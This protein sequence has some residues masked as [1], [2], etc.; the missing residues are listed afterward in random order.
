MG[1]KNLKAIAIRGTTPIPIA[2][3]S[4]FQSLVKAAEIKLAHSKG[5]KGMRKGGSI[6]FINPNFN[7]LAFK[8]YQDDTWAPERVNLITPDV[9][10]EKYQVGRSGCYNCN[11]KCGRLYKVKEGEFAGLE[12]EGV[13]INAL[14]G[15]GSNLD[16]ADPSH[17]I[18]ANAVCNQYGLNI[19]SIASIAGWV[20]DCFERGIITK[21][22]LGYRVDWGD[23]HSFLRLAKDVTFRNGLGD[24]LA[25]GIQRASKIIGKDSQRLA[26]IS[27]G[28]EINEGRLRSHRAWALG[29]MTSARGGGH[30]N[31]APATEG[32][33]FDEKLCEEIYG[34][35]NVNKPMAYENKAE[36]VV[37]T[38]QLKML[39]DSVGI[40]NFVCVWN[41]P[42]E[43]RDEDIYHL[44]KEA[45]GDKRSIGELLMVIKQAI[46]IEKAFNTIHGDFSRK[47]D[48]PPQRLT[49]EPIKT[50]AFKG[51]SISKKKWDNMLDE[52]YKLHGWDRVTGRQ[53]KDRLSKLSLDFVANRLVKKRRIY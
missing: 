2:N 7:P 51:A 49:I 36:F 43:L 13:Q 12:T 22:D 32:V 23:I 35:S 30:L 11:V 53:T 14:R 27:K 47:D 45:T 48:Y 25:E 21:S 38:E 40:C 4:A 9:F 33:G 24:E 46:N 34:I 31:G 50:G 8:N 18:K 52:Y 16:M 41:D 20:M 19:D 29:V 17:I 44:Y 37:R 15:L 1:S 6:S 3:P 5:I 42:E 26:V 28:V 10:K 39:V